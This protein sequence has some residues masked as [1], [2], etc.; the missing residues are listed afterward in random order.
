[1]FANNAF[2]PNVMI[3]NISVI[4]CNF[5]NRKSQCLHF[6]SLQGIDTYIDLRQA[7]KSLLDLIGFHLTLF[8]L[9]QINSRTYNKC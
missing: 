9:N 7:S 5:F 8:Q 1:M 3:H 4:G 6:F 2:T